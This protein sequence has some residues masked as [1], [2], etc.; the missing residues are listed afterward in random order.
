MLIETPPLVVILVRV[1][2]KCCCS[3]SPYEIKCGAIVDQV[4]WEMVLDFSGAI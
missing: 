2:I 4:R 3:T 1:E